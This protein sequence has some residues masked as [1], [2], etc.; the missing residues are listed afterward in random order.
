MAKMNKLDLN[1]LNE[2][3]S[4]D[5][6]T[7]CL[8]WKHRPEMHFKSNRIFK[9]WNT[10]FANKTAG[11]LIDG[12]IKIKINYKTYS[13]HRLAY[14]LHHG[15]FPEN[16]IDHKDRVRHHNWISNLRDTSR[17]CNIR[18]SGIRSDNASG[19]TGVGF[20]KRS[21]KWRARITV[22]DKQINLGG[23]K[24][25]DKAAKSRWKAEVK[26]KFPN[27]C[28][29]SSACNYLKGKNLVNV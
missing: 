29:D 10:K 25:F 20:N 1:Y 27:C 18:N 6:K 28:T 22:G 19:V 26:Y 24:N 3:L 16:E 15:Y 8:T 21:K 23:F 4:Y 11:T 14:A 2:C 13:A 17:L 5:Q 12:Y 9:T 7:G